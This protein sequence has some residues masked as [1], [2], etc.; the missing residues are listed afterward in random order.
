MSSA[1]GMDN[2]G[3]ATATFGALIQDGIASLRDTQHSRRHPRREPVSAVAAPPAPRASRA[4]PP[5]PLAPTPLPWAGG[6]ASAYAPTPTFAASASLQEMRRMGERL[7]FAEIQIQRALRAKLLLEIYAKLQK[8]AKHMDAGVVMGGMHI[9][10]PVERAL[11]LDKIEPEFPIVDRDGNR[12][13]PNTSLSRERSSHR[14]HIRHSHPAVR[15]HTWRFVPP[16]DPALD[17]HRLL[18]LGRFNEDLYTRLQS[19]LSASHMMR[20]LRMLVK[21]VGGGNKATTAARRLREIQCRLED[22]IMFLFEEIDVDRTTPS[23]R[24]GLVMRV[25]AESMRQ[26]WPHVTDDAASTSSSPATSTSAATADTADTNMVSASF[27]APTT[28]ITSRSIGSRF[29]ERSPGPLVQL[30]IELSLQPLLNWRRLFSDSEAAAEK[31]VNSLRERA[32]DKDDASRVRRQRMFDQL[33]DLLRRAR[34]LLLHRLRVLRMSLGAPED[35]THVKNETPVQS[36]PESS[37]RTASDGMNTT[38]RYFVERLVVAVYFDEECGIAKALNQAFVPR[39]KQLV[40]ALDHDRFAEQSGGEGIRGMEGVTGGSGSGNGEVLGGSGCISGVS[41]E[42][43]RKPRVGKGSTDDTSD[44]I[45][46]DKSFI[47]SVMEHAEQARLM[48]AHRIAWTTVKDMRLTGEWLAA[49]KAADSIRK[50]F[51]PVLELNMELEKR[52]LWQ[53]IKALAQVRT[54]KEIWPRQREPTGREHHLPGAEE[55]FS[56]LATEGMEFVSNMMQRIVDMMRVELDAYFTSALSTGALSTGAPSTGAGRHGAEALWSL[57][58]SSAFGTAV[59]NISMCAN[60]ALRSKDRFEL[61]FLRDS[62]GVCRARLSVIWSEFLRA[63]EAF[64]LLPQIQ[65]LQHYM[66]LS[67]EISGG[68]GKERKGA[69]PCGN[70]PHVH[71]L[72]PAELEEQLDRV[73][74]CIGREVHLVQMLAHTLF[75]TAE[76]VVIPCFRAT[77]LGNS[78][79]PVTT[80]VSY[81]ATSADSMARHHA[82]VLT[83]TVEHLIS[84]RVHD[85]LHAP[86]Q[87]AQVIVERALGECWLENC[88]VAQARNILRTAQRKEDFCV[89]DNV[90]PHARLSDSPTEA[91]RMICELWSRRRLECCGSGDA[92]KPGFLRGANRL[93]LERALRDRLISLIWD[94]VQTQKI[95]FTGA[96][97]LQIDLESYSHACRPSK[98]ASPIHAS[99]T[100]NLVVLGQRSFELLRTMAGVMAVA[101]EHVPDLVREV[102]SISSVSKKDFLRFVQCR[103]DFSEKS[104]V[105]LVRWIEEFYALGGMSMSG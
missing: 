3:K 8:E 54:R 80:A 75:D 102:P 15:E 48:E 14:H 73:A 4:S 66:D 16:G 83:A 56:R 70:V 5:V 74:S 27:S 82:D 98:L 71:E 55:S 9:Y 10:S 79:Q 49:A 53:Y 57:P 60:K 68:G 105:E 39:L 32:E 35:E 12:A 43:A 45:A 22:D 90:N 96:L 88:T 99:G 38:H 85:T 34:R 84:T 50:K 95:D 94:H 61:T 86:L 104:G 47:A 18:I 89:R 20:L 63:S 17:L 31:R 93:R 37:T 28:S 44:D 29:L 26:L 67:L 69:P 87:R 58:P 7:N 91:C 59:L 23:P 30:F 24:V 101:T 81:H 77:S 78:I 92:N 41:G 64:L 1:T 19:M 52:M 65:T 76:R 72:Q 21:K 51:R 25:C 33:T 36:R 100:D 2:G 6:V 97:R 103:A 11:A 13:P 62:V 40:G 42:A 46:H